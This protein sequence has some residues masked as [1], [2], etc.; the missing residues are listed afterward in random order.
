MKRLIDPT[1]SRRRFLKGLSATGL[2]LAAGPTWADRTMVSAAAARGSVTVCGNAGV[3][4]SQVSSRLAMPGDFDT[5]SSCSVTPDTVEGPYFICADTTIGKDIT[6]GKPGQAMSLAIRVVDQT[7]TPIPG[8]IVDAWHCDARGYYSG[9]DVDPDV[10]VRPAPG[11]REPDNQA[12][13]LRGVLATDVDGIAEFDAIYPGFYF[14]RP[15]HTHY[16]VHIGNQSFMTS[17]ALYP[18][19]INARVMAMAPYSDP[20]TS[21]R[22]PNSEDMPVIGPTGEF[23]IA[24]RAGRLLATITLVVST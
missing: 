1:K 12:R 21:T 9:H 14:G 19:D 20:R 24:E 6:G 17:Q 7:C 13:F 15:I 4:I 22:T 5:S 3:P 11:R 8:A 23:G 16:K 18:E 2:T 10:F